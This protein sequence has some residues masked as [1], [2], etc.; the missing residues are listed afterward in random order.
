MDAN[1]SYHPRRA[2]SKPRSAQNE[3]IELLK[4]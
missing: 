4:P 3:L 1:G 2:S